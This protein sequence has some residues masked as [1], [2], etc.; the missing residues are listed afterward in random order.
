MQI[1]SENQTCT[2][3]YNM[4][5]WLFE[6]GSR[7]HYELWIVCAFSPVGEMEVSAPSPQV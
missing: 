6:T 5:Q 3:K 2:Q 1:P 7:P 4:D